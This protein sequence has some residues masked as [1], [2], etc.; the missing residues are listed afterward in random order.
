MQTRERI[1]RLIDELP[2]ADVSAALRLVEQVKA[3]PMAYRD[4]VLGTST[5]GP[6]DDEPLSPDDEAALKEAYANVA[7]GRVFPHQVAR[8]R[9]IGRP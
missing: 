2:E 6:E 4:P 3:D 9:L 7:S 5:T 1:H 8:R